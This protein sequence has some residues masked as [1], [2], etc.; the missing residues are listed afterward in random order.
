[1]RSVDK[2]AIIWILALVFFPIGI[3]LIT[4]IN[5]VLSIIIS[6]SIILIIIILTVYY[7]KKD[8]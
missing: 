4:E 1:M 5:T 6:Y 3:Y 2:L 8:D 7:Y